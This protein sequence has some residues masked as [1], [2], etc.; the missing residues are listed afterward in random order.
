M[1]YINV[2]YSSA[3]MPDGECFKIYID[4]AKDITRSS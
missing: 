2:N 4:K 3:E 1:P